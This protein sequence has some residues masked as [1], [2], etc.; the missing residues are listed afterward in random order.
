MIIKDFRIPDNTWIQ[1]S[2]LKTKLENSIAIYEGIK[3]AHVPHGT[4]ASIWVDADL[5]HLNYIDVNYDHRKLPITMLYTPVEKSTKP[6]KISL[7]EKAPL[8]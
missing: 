6:K 1:G 5:T 2:Q 4:R 8:H 3:V 7:Q